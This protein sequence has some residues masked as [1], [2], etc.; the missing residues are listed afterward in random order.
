M[1]RPTAPQ[2]PA[3]TARNRLGA[4]KLNGSAPELIEAARRDL[5]AATIETWISRILTEAPPLTADQLAHLRALLHPG[6]GS[7]G[8]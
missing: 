8:A 3:Q 4:R 2:S 7:D 5:A 1:A 6:A